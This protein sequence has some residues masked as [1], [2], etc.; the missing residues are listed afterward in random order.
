MYASV[1]PM[2]RSTTSA[3]VI[4]QP[5]SVSTATSIRTA[6]RSLSTKTPS[7]SKITSR[8]GVLTDATLAV[9]DST[10]RRLGSVGGAQLPV[11]PGDDAGRREAEHDALRRLLEDAGA[12]LRGQVRARVARHEPEPVIAHARGI[13]LD[14]H[15][16]L[17]HRAPQLAVHVAPGLDLH[18]RARVALEIPDLLGLA[19]CPGEE[20]GTFPHVPERHQVGAAVRPDGRAGQHALLVE[21]AAQLC[22]GHGDVVPSRWQGQYPCSRSTTWRRGRPARYRA[23]LSL[24]TGAIASG[25]LGPEMCGV[26]TTLSI[27]QS[28]WLGGSGSRSKTSRTAPAMRFCSSASSS[29]ASLTTAPRAMLMSQAVGF[30]APSASGPKIPRVSTVRGRSNT[31]KSASRRAW[32]MAVTGYMRAAARAG[33]PRRETPS[34]R[35]PSPRA[36]RAISRPMSPRPTIVMVLPASRSG[37]T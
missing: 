7:Q 34:T 33:R 15:V 11:V 12:R 23:R 27:R 8:M 28:G 14:R 10:S 4:G 31:T 26:T 36:T 24:K 29:A 16:A 37:R 9:R 2:N 13:A 1:R 5:S 3:S 17:E 30:M 18:R 19:V 21:E 32:A 25:V 20:R 6:M 35:I 22:L